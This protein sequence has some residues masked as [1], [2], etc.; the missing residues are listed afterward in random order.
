[1]NDDNRPKDLPPLG[2]YDDTK[3]RRII[4]SELEEAVKPLRERIAAMEILLDARAFEARERE[5]LLAEKE[6]TIGVLR[7]EIVDIKKNRSD[8]TRFSKPINPKDE[9]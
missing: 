5:R 4:A 1:M 8:P 6:S 9:Q 3:D 2:G 7:R